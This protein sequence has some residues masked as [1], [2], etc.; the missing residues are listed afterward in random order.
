MRSFITRCN[1]SKCA[2]FFTTK[3][4]KDTKCGQ[5][6]RC[7][8]LYRRTTMRATLRGLRKL[9]TENLRLEIS[10]QGAKTQSSDIS[11]EAI[12]LGVFASWREISFLRV[13]RALH[14]QRPL[15][16]VLCSVS[17]GLTRFPTLSGGRGC[18][19][20]YDKGRSV[21]SDKVFYRLLRPR[22][23]CADASAL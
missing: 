10:R 12:F 14:G 11:S 4:T 16:P 7:F 8:L 17:A 21:P 15:S 1:L 6:H 20:A 9:I 18:L 19:A 23:G 22:R 3:Q 5:K 2:H 13:L